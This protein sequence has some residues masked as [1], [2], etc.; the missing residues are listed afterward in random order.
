MPLLNIKHLDILPSPILRFRLRLAKYEYSAHHTPGKLL[1]A[2]DALSRAP[3]EDRGEEELRE[4]VES[5]VNHITMFFIPA[6][7]QILEQISQAQ[8]ED[9]QCSQ[10]RQFCK[11]GWPGRESIGSLFKPYWKARFPTNLV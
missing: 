11:T 6:T 4:E 7:P 5:H 9:A 3:T 1:Y 8:I 10:A 2:A